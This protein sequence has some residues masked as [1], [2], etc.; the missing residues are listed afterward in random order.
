MISYYKKYQMDLKIR[1]TISRR[2]I[3]KQ[4]V[5]LDLVNVYVGERNNICIQQEM[6]QRLIKRSREEM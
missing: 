5:N 4:F 2:I 1:I 6:L 3:A